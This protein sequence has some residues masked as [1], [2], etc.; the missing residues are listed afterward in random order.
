MDGFADGRLEKVVRADHLVGGEGPHDGSGIALVQD[1]RGKPDGC[2]R[3]LGLGL[4]YQVGV[5]DLGKLAA[6]RIA[7][8]LAGNNQHPVSGQRV[9]PVI[10]GA[11][12]RT[13]RTREVVEE[14][15][16]CGS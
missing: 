12:Q 8:R 11:Q 14:F 6:H 15:G 2:R 1:G 3:I 7:V 16:S 4:E 13:A 5:R 10:G 9:Q